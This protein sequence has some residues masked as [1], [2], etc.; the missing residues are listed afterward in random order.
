MA[1]G[2]KQTSSIYSEA[3]ESISVL[4]ADDNITYFLFR[5][6]LAFTFS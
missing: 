5:L 6:T 3:A 2:L 4:G 1:T